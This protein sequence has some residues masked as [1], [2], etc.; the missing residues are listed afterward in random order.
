MVGAFNATIRTGTDALPD[1]LAGLRVSNRRYVQQPGSFRHRA[2]AL[3]LRS[4]SRPNLA[5]GVVDGAEY[6]ARFS[7]TPRFGAWVEPWRRSGPTFLCRGQR[8]S[9]VISPRNDGDVR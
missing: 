1:R 9:P 2:H 3:M 7:G 8:V 4:F 5:E 6:G